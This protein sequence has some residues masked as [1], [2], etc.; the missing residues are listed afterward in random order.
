MCGR[1]GSGRAR[2]GQSSSGYPHRGPSGRL[3]PA[4][5]RLHIRGTHPRRLS[6]ISATGT[7]TMREHRDPEVAETEAVSGAAEPRARQ[8][9]RC[10][11]GRARPARGL[12]MG[13]VRAPPLAASGAVPRE[14]MGNRAPI[15]LPDNR[16]ASSRPIK[17]GRYRSGAFGVG[18]ESDNRSTLGT[19]AA[20]V[21]GAQLEGCRRRA[22][23][24]CLPTEFW[25]CGLGKSGRRQRMRG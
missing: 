10:S 5:P 1:R 6:R 24:A 3:L 12:P 7:R 11:V 18:L 9:W 8:R 25:Q 15:G 22:L 2:H 13:A 16:S 19:G 20:S 4:G 23:P 14:P 17:H 21:P